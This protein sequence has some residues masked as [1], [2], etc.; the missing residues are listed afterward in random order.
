[1]R[2][3]HFKTCISQFE[4]WLLRNDLRPEQREAIQACLKRIKELAKMRNRTESDI[5]QCVSV[6]SKR[7][8]EVWKREE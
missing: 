5:A 2:R 6:L 4:I 7:L 8:F 1:M 3:K